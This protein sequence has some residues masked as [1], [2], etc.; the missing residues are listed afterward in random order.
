MK[1]HRFTAIVYRED[2]MYVAECLEVGTVDLRRN[3][4]TSDR[5]FD[6]SNAALRASGIEGLVR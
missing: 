2:D 3:N 1:T 6:R 5:G 4:R